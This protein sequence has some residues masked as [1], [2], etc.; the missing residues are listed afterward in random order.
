M[1]DPVTIPDAPPPWWQTLIGLALRK[2]LS[3]SAGGLAVLGAL[4]P[5]QQTQVYAWMA[6]AVFTVL[7]TGW[8]TLREMLAR[9]RWWNAIWAKPPTP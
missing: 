7:S 9:A 2:L 6:A 5:D 8:S 4:T 1:S 3:S